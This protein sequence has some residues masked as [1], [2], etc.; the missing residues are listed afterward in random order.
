MPGVM[1][2]IRERRSGRA[3]TA[4]PVT[5]GEL[6]AVLEAGRLAPSCNNTQAWDFVVVTDS[7]KRERAN[8]TLSRGNAWAKSAP[9]MV[10]VVTREGGGCGAHDLPY[11]MMD[12]GL[13]VENMLL[14]AVHLGLMGH[15]T[16]G[17]DEEELRRVL[18]I[19]DDRRVATVVF[20][21]RPATLDEVPEELREREAK[22]SPR[23]PREEVVHWDTW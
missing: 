14:Q 23:R 12:V 5:Q 7:E 17:W 10:V 15:A 18:E 20:F 11:Y 19:P 22:R 9:V 21:G 1:R 8:A 6:L 13:A 3:F 16:A 2:E 4:R